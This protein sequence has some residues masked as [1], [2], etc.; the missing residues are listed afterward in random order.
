MAEKLALSSRAII[1]RFY[2]TLE[3][4]LGASWASRVGMLFNSNQGSEEYEWLGMSPALR[5]WIDGRQAK[6]LRSV[7]Y[8]IVN[9]IFEATLA[10]LVDDLRRDKTGQIMVRIDEMAA[11]AVTHWEALLSALILVGDSTTCYDGQ[12]FFDTDHSEL[13][14][15]TQINLVTASQVSALNVGTATAP[16]AA[17]MAEC[18]MGVLAYFY[19][20]LDDQG[21][22]INGDARN[23]LV[24]VPVPLWAPT[25]TA[26]SANLLNKAAGSL[27][28][29]MQGLFKQGI[30]V[31]I[32][33]N[34]RL[35]SWTDKFA[36]FRTDGRA[37]PFILQEEEGLSVSAVAEGSEEEFKNN[38]H[39]YGIKAIRNV[40]FGLW[41]HAIRATLS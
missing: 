36:I 21:E 26:V 18:L 5:E 28:N 34:P 27:D 32:V 33:A 38:R 14:S 8:T 4:V 7:G 16:T 17:E 37:K 10:I 2:Q 6:G 20:Y 39:L 15:G 25:V 22:P 29:P 40:G 41:Q 11:R 3:A 9:K 31:D 23:F 30:N 19:T 24:M 35:S 1:G 13:D 12:Y